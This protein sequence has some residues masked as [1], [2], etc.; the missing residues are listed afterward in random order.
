M[1]HRR[2]SNLGAFILAT[3]VPFVFD[4]EHLRSVATIAEYN[5]DIIVSLRNIG[6]SNMSESFGQ[7]GIGYQSKEKM[8]AD[9]RW[10]DKT[11]HDR[12]M[13]FSGVS[14]I[15]AGN[16]LRGIP[17]NISFASGVPHGFVVWYKNVRIHDDAM[18]PCCHRKHEKTNEERLL[19]DEKDERVEL[20]ERDCIRL[21]DDDV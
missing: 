4:G 1:L 18:N 5:N 11:Q 15:V 10:Y 16:N 19:H 2:K 13:C 7:I 8:L 9:V 12:P 20:D 3:F 14:G 21:T 17:S 6:H